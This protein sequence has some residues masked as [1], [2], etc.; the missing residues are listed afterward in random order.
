MTLFDDLQESERRF[1]EQLIIQTNRDPAAKVSMYEVGE[2]VN[3][4]RPASKHV[5]EMLIGLGL[6]EIRTLSGAIGITSDGIDIAQ[7]LQCPGDHPVPGAFVLGDKRIPDEPI[8][9]ALD[10]LLCTLKSRIP[11]FGLNFEGLSELM[12]DIKSID[13]QLASPKP[14]TVVLRGCLE[15]IQE[16]LSRIGER[17][18]MTRVKRFLGT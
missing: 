16:T 11:D 10:I 8:L 4:D 14:K 2:K 6:V 13:A 9:K 18:F 7:S 12:A 17:D 1:L 15:S 5:A 3:L